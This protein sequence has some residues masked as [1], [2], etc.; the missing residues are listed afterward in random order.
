[1]IPRPFSKRAKGKSKTF[2]RLKKWQG[3]KN[4]LSF[5][6]LPLVTTKTAEG[7]EEFQ[8]IQAGLGERSLLISGN[9][10]I[11]RFVLITFKICHT[12]MKYP[13]L[14]STNCLYAAV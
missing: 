10:I 11:L 8:P 6:L 9:I 12:S 2:P 5:Y 1:M 13:L 4:M 3:T 14:V 7:S